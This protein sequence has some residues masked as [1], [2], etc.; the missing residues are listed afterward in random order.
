MYG[1]AGVTAGD[2]SPPG[3][4]RQS[5][6]PICNE[7]VQ[8]M[9]VTRMDSGAPTQV[10]ARVKEGATAD[11]QMPTAGGPSAQRPPPTRQARLLPALAGVLAAAFGL[12]IG[13]LWAGIFNGSGPV[14]VV[15]DRVVDG[16]PGSVKTFAIDTFGKNDKNAL[17]VGILVIMGIYAAFAGVRAAK[18]F[19]DGIVAV[20]AFAVIGGY[21]AIS[22]RSPKAADIV[23]MAVSALAVIAALW[24]LL[25]RP[26]VR[27]ATGVERR[28]GMDRRRFLVLGAGTAGAAAVTGI[29]GRNLQGGAKAVAQRKSTALPAATEKLPAV[30]AGTTADVVGMTPYVTPNDAFYRI[31]T[32]LVIPRVEVSNWKMTITGQVDKP[33]TFTYAD[34]LKRPLVEHDCT[35]MCVSN[36]IG[37]DLVGNARWL[38]VRLADILK[39]AGVQ[40]GADQVF[41]SSVDG[42]T[43]G[44]PVSLAMD[45]REALIAIG[46]NGEPLPFRHGFPA[47]LVVPGI[48]GYVSAVKWLSD[49]RLT[50][51]EESQGYWIPR[52]WS[53]LGPIKTGS[54]ID[55]PG[56]GRVVAGNTAIAGV[57]W[58]QHT[59]I[60][61]VEVQVDGTPWQ[62]AE[63]AVDG[64]VD[65]W[66]QWKLAWNA[67]AGDHR[68][69]VRATDANGK[70]QT[71]ERADVAPD[72]ATGWHEIGV[73]VS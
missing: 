45:G 67:T 52:G 48:Y 26:P 25:G 38:G 13:E 61:K 39:E 44:F 11:T 2:A 23:P 53:A 33:L 8:T 51:F 62:T 10:V 34:L 9:D 54:R 50:T 22:G 68:I 7:Q 47:R 55:V 35:L 60:S 14:V 30:A 42:F 31:D 56:R 18:R 71:E 32:A 40:K 20:A 15:G 5:T 12:G 58:A 49:I 41:A 16:V 46:M 3:V 73:S 1:L 6:A 57:A 37:G 27:K 64:G 19:S 69:R 63:L 28:L 36:E 17:V 59:G 66:R 21:A 70:V 24:V 4:P 65:T 72:G 43:A 29:V